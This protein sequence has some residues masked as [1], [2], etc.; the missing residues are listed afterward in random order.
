M[1]FFYFG[2]IIK[3]PRVFVNPI[4]SR[5]HSHT[6]HDTHSLLFTAAVLRGSP[7]DGHKSAGGSLAP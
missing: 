4:C 6:S 7:H 5:T 2:F 3:L 1:F